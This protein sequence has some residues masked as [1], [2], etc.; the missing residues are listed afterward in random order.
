MERLSLHQRLRVTRLHEE[1]ALQFDPNLA[2]TWRREQ[3]RDGWAAWLRSRRWDWWATLT[4]RRELGDEIAAGLDVEQWLRKLRAAAPGAAAAVSIERG[5]LTGR[6]HAHALVFTAGGLDAERLRDEWWRWGQM[7]V[8]PFRPF[9]FSSKPQQRG[10]AAR[11]L[12]KEPENVELHG[13]PPAYRP[14]RQR[15]GSLA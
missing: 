4:W 12:V 14:R 2:D 1:L 8:E 15:P 3:W 7:H 11:Y 9:R 10:K 13:L 6:L 5:K